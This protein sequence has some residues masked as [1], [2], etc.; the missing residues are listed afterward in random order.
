MWPFSSSLSGVLG[1][2]GRWESDGQPLLEK[3]GPRWREGGWSGE[4]RATFGALVGG[5][6]PV[7]TDQ[8]GKE[9]GQVN[10]GH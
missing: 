2:R 5:R 8:P 6:L 1:R 7:Y 4:W 3:Y 9:G 10:S